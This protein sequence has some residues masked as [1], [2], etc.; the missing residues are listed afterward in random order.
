MTKEFDYQYLNVNQ[1]ASYIQRS[2]GAIRN[3]VLRKA[4]P[5][6]K[7][8]GRLIFLKKEIDQWIQMAP[9]R[10]LEEIQNEV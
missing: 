1:L 8:A 3:L 9:G 6:R 7:P 5:Y 10:K 4:I 2:K